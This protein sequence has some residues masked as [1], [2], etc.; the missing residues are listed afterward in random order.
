MVSRPGWCLRRG[1]PNPILIGRIRAKGRIIIGR[2]LRTLCPVG[3]GLTTLAEVV[4]GVRV[5]LQHMPLLTQSGLEH[6]QLIRC[7]RESPTPSHEDD[8]PPLWVHS[9]AEQQ[10]VGQ[11][12]GTHVQCCIVMGLIEQ[13][14]KA[15]DRCINVFRVGPPIGQKIH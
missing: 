5:C 6:P 3:R 15:S 1:R 14:I 2:I 11:D 9:E 4:D 7:S 8:R 13:D 12:A 10:H